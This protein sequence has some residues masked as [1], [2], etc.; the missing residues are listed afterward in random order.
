MRKWRP[1]NESA[2]ED[3]AVHHQ[4]VVPESY[5]QEI[6][7][8]A[9]DT[10][11]SGH[12]GVNKTYH[13]ISQ[14]FYWPNMKNDV[15]KFCR[16]CHTCQMVGKPNQTIPKAHL[17]PIPAFEEPF[18]RILVDCVGPLPKTRSGNEYMLTIMCTSTR[19]PEAIPLRNIK[20][21]TVV[22]ALMKFFTPLGL[23]N[24]MQSNPG[25]NFVSVVL[26]QVMHEL[27]TDEKKSSAHHHDQRKETPM[28][29]VGMLKR[30]VWRDKPCENNHPV[31]RI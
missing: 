16:S 15:A 28:L 8:M 3:W 29:H 10:P 7:S 4:V 18:S 21:K 19:F 9:H 30:Y 24:S 26:Q 23:P 25:S 14:H 2:D 17:Q 5:R 6:I 11:L 12:L 13:K 27:E 1:P 31:R 20:A 22:K